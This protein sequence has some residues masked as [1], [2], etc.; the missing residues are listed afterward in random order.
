MNR[1]RWNPGKNSDLLIA[2]LGLLFA[3]AAVTNALAQE[4]EDSG[5]RR[6]TW[7]EYSLAEGDQDKAPAVRERNFAP[8]VTDGSRSTAKD[9]RRLAKVTAAASRKPNT[10]FWFYAADVELF[11]DRDLDGYYHGIDILFDADTYFTEAEVYAVLY[12]S[13]E[14]GPW[15]EFAATENFTIFGAVPDDDYVVVTEL[16]AGY[17]TG[18]YDVLIELFDAFDDSFVAFIGPED[19]SELAFL[20]LEDADRDKPVFTDSVVIVEGGGG[21]AGGILLLALTVAALKRRYRFGLAALQAVL[22]TERA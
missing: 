17:P 15:N 4:S 22:A 10:D 2:V 8:L 7:T 16:V 18:D 13:L 19:T 3:L 12:L 9:S 20:P 21:A 5:E 11:N 1:I 6:S 14:G